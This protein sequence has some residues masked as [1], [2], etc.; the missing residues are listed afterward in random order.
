[1]SEA[2]RPSGV[3]VA[4]RH[5]RLAGVVWLGLVLSLLPVLAGIVPLTRAFD[6]GPFRESVVKGWD[7]WAILSWLA[8][9]AREWASF[10]PLFYLSAALGLFVQLLLAGGILRTLLADVRRP[11]LKRVVTEGAALFR[12]SLWAFVRFLLTL[13]FWEG[14]LVGG[15]LWLLDKIGGESAPPN[16][17]LDAFAVLWTVVV[18]LVVFLNVSAR[19]DLARV[20]LA[21]DDSPT[22]RG[23]YRVAKERLRGNRAS[24]CLVVLSWLVAGVAVEALFTDLGVSLAPHTNA[25]TFW[26]VV[27]RQLGFVVLAMTRVGFWGSLLKWEE[28]RRPA[29]RPVTPW[30][31]PEPV[32]LAAAPPPAPE[33]AP[34]SAPPEASF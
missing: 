19:F 33:A 12:P 24:A 25:G 14:V 15:M 22:A 4:L 30:R 5:R 3:A 2:S 18:G 29:P 34:P 20:A 31:A 32:V 27:F 6:E 28:E 17:G 21:R 10:R 1:V 26:L 7:S 16:G 9:K 13:L 23:A 11:V 8:F